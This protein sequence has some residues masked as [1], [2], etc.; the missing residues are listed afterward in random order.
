[1]RL[2]TRSGYS[3]I[4]DALANTITRFTVRIDKKA[5]DARCRQPP[6]A[7]NIK[8]AESETFRYS[9]D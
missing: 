8:V 7:Q 5:S 3:T 2:A 9:M 6:T 1:M 4:T